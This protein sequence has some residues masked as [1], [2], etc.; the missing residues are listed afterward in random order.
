MGWIPGLGRSPGGG[1]GN[2]LQYSYL[3]NPMDRGAWRVMVY[4]LSHF[5][6]L[7]LLSKNN[8]AQ[9]LQMNENVYITLIPLKKKTLISIGVILVNEIN[10]KPNFQK[11]VFI[12]HM[13]LNYPL[14]NK[15]I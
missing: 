2:P 8:L 6:A 13:Q 12:D 3:K 7:S 15:T 10:L 9:D 4:R 11:R 1:Q 5:S 14:K